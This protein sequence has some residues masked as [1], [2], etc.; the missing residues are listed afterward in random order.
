[1]KKTLLAT[2][3]GILLLTSMAMASAASYTKEEFLT[4]MLNYGYS[5]NYKVKNG[6]Y[7]CGDTKNTLNKNNYEL[8]IDDLNIDGDIDDTTLSFNGSV[9]AV[10]GTVKKKG[11]KGIYKVNLT[12][13]YASE[14]ASGTADVTVK[15]TLK[16]NDPY[17]IKKMTVVVKEHL[18]ADFNERECTAKATIKNMEADTAVLD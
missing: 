5:E 4:V 14:Q 2:T 6:S 17:T 13:E 11:N 15:A 1:M 18:T 10:E 12:G 7:K 9:Y 16:K 8:D 3:S